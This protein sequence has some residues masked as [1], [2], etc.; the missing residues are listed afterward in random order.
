MEEMKSK[1]IVASLDAYE[2]NFGRLVP[3]STSV[4]HR[5]ETA[6]FRHRKAA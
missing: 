2:S 6:T 5:S 4:M 3:V 1:K